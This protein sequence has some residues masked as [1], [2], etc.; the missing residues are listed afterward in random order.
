[1]GVSAIDLD[2]GRLPSHDEPHVRDHQS[3]QARVR[4]RG[5]GSRSGRALAAVAVGVVVALTGACSAG[6]PVVG[7]MTP[8]GRQGP[9]PVLGDGAVPAGPLAEGTPTA[10]DPPTT[11]R[12][13]GVVPVA[14]PA[15]RLAVTLS[16][17]GTSQPV[18]F[19]GVDDGYVRSRWLLALEQQ[20]HLPFTAFLTN[21]AWRQDPGYWRQ[22]QAAGVR[23]EDHTLTHPM[24]TG[25]ARTQVQ[26]QICVAATADTA[27]FGRRPVLFRPPYGGTN[28]VVRRAAAG[29]GM[30]DA[31]G[32]AVGRHRQPG[33]VA[34]RR[35]PPAPAGGRHRADA[36][37]GPRCNRT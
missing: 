5:R 36:L 12:A 19:L 26:R 28:A 6:A 3:P 30:R 1:M 35:S 4:G 23:I 31:G 15:T 13:P 20:R 17:V 21:A 25:L 37:L 32:G 16:R 22:L 11:R 2:A 7:V 14:V 10:Q 27:A 33:G 8:G 34:V 9:A 24:L 29:C 18:V